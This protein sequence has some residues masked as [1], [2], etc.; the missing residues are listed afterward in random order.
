MGVF[1]ILIDFMK[2]CLTYCFHFTESIGY[3]SYGIAII[4]LTLAIKLC[5][6]P[7]TIKQLRSMKALQKVQPKMKVLQAK[8]KNDK[9]RLNQELAKLYSESGVNPLSGCLPLIV[10]MPFLFAIFYALRD[11]NYVEAYKSFLWLPSL[12]SPDPYYILPVVSAFFTWLA[13]RASGAAAQGGP[14]QK[15]MQAFMPLFIGYISLKFPSGLVIYWALSN[16]IQ[17]VTTLIV[18]REKGAQ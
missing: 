14:Q 18:N 2:T 4:L 6:T 5:L 11:Y 12:G 13:S 1:D 9:E 15:M 10:Q 16:L 8:Y 3:P 17:L 7:L